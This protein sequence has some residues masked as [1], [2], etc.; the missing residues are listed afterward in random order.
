MV[1]AVQRCL[2]RPN[3]M[4]VVTGHTGSGKTTTPYAALNALND[5]KRKIYPLT[6]CWLLT[7]PVSKLIRRRILRNIRRA[8][9]AK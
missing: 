6:A 1:A 3:G 2:K 5:S 8:A 4:F 9:E 7:R